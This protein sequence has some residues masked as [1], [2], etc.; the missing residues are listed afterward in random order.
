[1]ASASSSSKHMEF[2]GDD[3]STESVDSDS[4][5]GSRIAASDHQQPITSNV[6]H[7]GTPVNIINNPNTHH[8][9]H[10]LAIASRILPPKPWAHKM[11]ISLFPHHFLFKLPFPH[12]HAQVDIRK[13]AEHVILLGG[14]YFG[15]SRFALIADVSQ[16][17]WILRGI[18]INYRYIRI[19]LTAF[20]Y[21]NLVRLPS[22]QRCICSLLE[23]NLS[24]RKVPLL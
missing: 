1:M 6:T 13:F 5:A 3:S 17:F 19:M 16:E 18:C 23:L 15:L 21:Q 10:T 20:S 22:C 9:S 2:L 4:I 8:K 24:L 12:I 7:S 11:Y 14:L